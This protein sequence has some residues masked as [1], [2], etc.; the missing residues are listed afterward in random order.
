MYDSILAEVPATPTAMARWLGTHRG[1]DQYYAQ[2]FDGVS[3]VTCPSVATQ[4]ALLP[5]ESP[6]FELLP[7]TG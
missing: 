7:V 5:Q 6:S 2:R 1:I 3:L 4:P